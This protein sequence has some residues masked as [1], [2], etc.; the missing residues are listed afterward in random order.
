MKLKGSS[1]LKQSLGA[2]WISVFKVPISLIL[3][4]ATLLAVIAA[5]VAWQAW[6]GGTSESTAASVEARISQAWDQFSLTVCGT[7]GIF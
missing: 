3:A 4:S 7:S 2:A 5:V 1:A 6:P